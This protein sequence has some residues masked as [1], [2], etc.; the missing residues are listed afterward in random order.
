VRSP[1][2]TGGTQP[3][4]TPRLAADPIDRNNK[5]TLASGQAPRTA[6]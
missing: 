3:A 5:T 1:A 2:P 6:L 4:T